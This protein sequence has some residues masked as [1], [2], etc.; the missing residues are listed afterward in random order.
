MTSP[1]N[2]TFILLLKKYG[3]KKDKS[4]AYS[5]TIGRSS[6]KIEVLPGSL[7]RCVDDKTKGH[8]FH[9]VL[10]TLDTEPVEIEIIP[11][12]AEEIPT[13]TV[14]LLYPIANCGDRL[15][16]YNDRNW[17][18]EGKT[19]KVG[20]S[21]YVKMKI[22]G[23]EL[24]GIV[25]YRGNFKDM[26]GIHF[27]VE[28][29]DD[30]GR[31][32]SNGFAHG[33]QYF[34]CAQDTGVFCTVNK[35]R[36]RRESF[37]RSELSKAEGFQ[38]NNRP[39]AQNERKMLGCNLVIGDRI[40]WVKDNGEP[41]DGTVKWIG[42]LPDSKLKDT[43]VGVEF[44]HPVGSGTGK[45]SEHRLFYAKQNHASLIPV[46]GLIKADEYYPEKAP[47]NNHDRDSGLYTEFESS[48]KSKMD[49]RRYL[50]ENTDNYSK[51][52]DRPVRV[53]SKDDSVI[54]KDKFDSHDNSLGLLSSLPL[55][56]FD[57]GK[58]FR[59]R[60][61]KE[62]GFSVYKTDRHNGSKYTNTASGRQYGEG[63]NPMYEYSKLETVT[64]NVT[65]LS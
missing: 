27:G 28:L 12:E 36:R 49:N 17:L 38:F 22:D 37:G 10:I 32:T 30:H 47:D 19:I 63:M 40:V 9:I 2:K 64:H 8:T 56:Q 42:T 14:E 6:K 39:S 13:E 62:N 41:E 55:Y 16:V 11:G 29:I 48:L 52:T 45:Y 51:T 4:S 26:R 33:R 61:S 43:T 21:V 3:K 1:I 18:A 46:M 31:G 58:D 34:K 53:S 65:I 15:R 60:G 20:D 5:L 23:S 57:I 25:R 44:D 54:R 35:M 50:A 59:G 7:L 24:P